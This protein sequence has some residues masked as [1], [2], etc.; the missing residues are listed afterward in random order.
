MC[1]HME[2]LRGSRTVQTGQHFPLLPG[3]IMV[4]GGRILDSRRKCLHGLEALLP[5]SH[6]ISIQSSSSQ[7]NSVMVITF[8]CNLNKTERAIYSVQ[9]Q[10]ENAMLC[11][12]AGLCSSSEALSSP[13][14]EEEGEIPAQY[15]CYS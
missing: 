1:S 3:L 10:W 4:D 14:S 6:C 15:I 2:Q 13:A 11:D 12:S 8:L 7:V 9:I 5:Q